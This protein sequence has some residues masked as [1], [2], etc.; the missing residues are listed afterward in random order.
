[1]RSGNRLELFDAGEFSLKRTFLIECV[2]VNDFDRAESS[3]DIA[4]QPDFAIASSANAAEQVVV[5]NSRNELRFTVFRTGH[6]VFLTSGSFRARD[7][8]QIR[9]LSKTCEY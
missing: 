7:G 9:S 2:T 4:G 6:I 8:L 1:M 5:G 3:H